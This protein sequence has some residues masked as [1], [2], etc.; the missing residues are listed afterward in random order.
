MLINRRSIA[1]ATLVCIVTMLATPVVGS[2]VTGQGTW[3]TTLLPR[4]LNG[5]GDADAYYDTDLNITWLRDWNSNGARPWAEQVT[6]VENL[7]IHGVTGWRLPRMADSPPVGCEFSFAGG[8]DCGYSVDT[9]TS[10]MAHM[11][12]VTLGNTA[13][14]DPLTSTELTCSGPPPGSGL[15]NSGDF[16]N[17][18][19]F[20]YW[21]GTPAVFKAN[22]AWMFNT[23]DG[24][25]SV[26]SLNQK[27]YAVA[28]RD[29]DVSPV[30]LP[31][32][33]WLLLSGLGAIGWMSRRPRAQQS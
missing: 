3:E 24:Y 11:F 4:D 6:W 14:C 23:L 15:T 21:T 31:A 8:T 26:G 17:L 10:D 5:D 9:A 22:N 1:T 19:P 7:D 12:Y 18:Q 27:W 32:A 2:A 25:Q 20:Y 29:G 28:V 33:A 13:V 30:P 16:R